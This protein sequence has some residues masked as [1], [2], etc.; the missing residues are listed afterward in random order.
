MGA[1]LHEK[2]GSKTLKAKR[3]EKAKPKLEK[4]DIHYQKLNDTF[5]KVSNWTQNNG[6]LY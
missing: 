3:R 1:N 6:D 5:L 2:D 4:I